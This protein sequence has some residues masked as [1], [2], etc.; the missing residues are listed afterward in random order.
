[1]ADLARPLARG[2]EHPDAEV[3]DLARPARAGVHQERDDVDLG[4]PEVVALVAAAGHALGRH[5]Q[6]L[7]ARRGLH[8]VEEVEAHGPLELGRALDLDVAALPERGHVP[9]VLALDRLV[10][11]EPGAVE[12]AVDAVDEVARR[13]LAADQW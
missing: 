11:V 4:V 9:R 7:G 5:A 3:E 8:E 10:A 13:R 12:R 2:V 1:M 6:A